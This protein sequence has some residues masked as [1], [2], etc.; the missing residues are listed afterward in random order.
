MVCI[1]TFPF[2]EILIFFTYVRLWSVDMT[3]VNEDNFNNF[4]S[5]PW[6][7]AAQVIAQLFLIPSSYSVKH[8]LQHCRKS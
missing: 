5:F 7:F 1:N 3:I 2:T 6:P 8:L 4:V